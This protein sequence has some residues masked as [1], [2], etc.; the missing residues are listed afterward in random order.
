MVM[1]AQKVPLGKVTRWISGG[2]PNRSVLK[3]WQG[4]IPWISAATLK[5]VEISQSDQHVSNEGLAVGSRIA[6]VDSTL[7]LVRGSALYNE[8][9]AGLVIRPVCFNQDVK[10][11]IP[12]NSIVPKFLTYSLLGR[13]ED[14][15]KLVSTAGNSAGVLDIKLLKAFEILLPPL[16]EQHAIAKALSD[17]DGL[18]GALDSL[19]AK[20]RAI[21]QAAMQQ[22]LTGK[23]RLPGF[24]GEWETK[25]LGDL[26]YC[27]RG[28]SYNP[29]EDISPHDTESTVRLF[30]S[31]NI[32]SAI[33]KSDDLQ[34]VDSRK[35]SKTQLMQP[36]DVLIC[37]ANGSKELVGKAGL[38]QVTD[39]YLYTFGAFMGCFRSVSNYADAI[40]VFYL[41]HTKKY[42]NFINIILAGSSINNL[43]PS[44]VE[45]TKFLMPKIEEQRAIATVLSDMDAEITALEQRR[46]KTH[47]I[48]Q[49]MMQ[50]LLTG[51]VRLVKAGV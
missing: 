43:K 47:Q 46:D 3:Y 20:K 9:R 45:S 28:V 29:L 34:F 8:I 26:G 17:V 23:T 10:A 41:F 25:R 30:R 48:K 19:I 36:N 42:R 12:N 35:V 21:K 50:Q 49:G 15:L 38:F 18:L 24:S 4:D 32:Q 40:F 27:I 13:E 11:L 33:I 51:R 7:F 5:N 44:D 16:E 6:P 39:G 37:M 22:L 31:N 14:I 1:S 2:T